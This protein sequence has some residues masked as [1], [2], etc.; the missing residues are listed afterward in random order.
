MAAG[1]RVLQLYLSD[2]QCLFPL[3]LHVSL[4]CEQMLKG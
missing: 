1:H 4:T 2:H 3:M